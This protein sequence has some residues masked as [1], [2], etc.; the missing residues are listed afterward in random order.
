M[1]VVEVP[2]QPI[3]TSEQIRAL[4]DVDCDE[5]NVL[6]KSKFEFN[7]FLKRQTSDVAQSE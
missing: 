7:H 1:V 5:E 6:L 2:T 3:H 4:E